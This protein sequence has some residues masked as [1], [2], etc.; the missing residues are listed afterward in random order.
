[1]SDM[2]LSARELQEY[3]LDRSSLAADRAAHAGVCPDCRAEIEAYTLLMEGLGRQPKPAFDFDVAAAVL[4]QLQP[5]EQKADRR[6]RYILAAVITVITGVSALLFWRS[7]YFVFTDISAVFLYPA[8]AAAGLFI[9]LKT[10]Q[11]YKKYQ[12]IFH[13]LNK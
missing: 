11:L 1:M 12:Q 9:L 3:I 2:H 6:Y 8:L 10:L 7:A 4:A 5:A 13:L